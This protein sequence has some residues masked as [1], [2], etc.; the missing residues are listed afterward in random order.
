MGPPLYAMPCGSGLVAPVL[1]TV[2]A[3][4]SFS[5]IDMAILRDTYSIAVPMSPCPMASSMNCCDRIVEHRSV[6]GSNVICDENVGSVAVCVAA[7]SIHSEVGSA[8]STATLRSLVMRMTLDMARIAPICCF[9]STM[10]RSRSLGMAAFVLLVE[11]ARNSAVSPVATAFSQRYAAS[12]DALRAPLA[13]RERMVGSASS[14]ARRASV[15]LSCARS[16][17][18]VRSA[19]MRA[20]TCFSSPLPRVS[21]D[22]GASPVR[23]S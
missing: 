14:F 11:S 5:D 15:A 6:R 19:S 13:G 12:S 20:K 18:A 9:F 7:S 3:C 1:P 16:S 8:F 10:R 23:A 21:T 2:N 22:C 17:I 4:S